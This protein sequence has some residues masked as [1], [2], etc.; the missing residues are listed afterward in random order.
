M[1]FQKRLEFIS[2]ILFLLSADERRQLW[3][4]AFAVF[5]MAALEVM[6]IASIT[7][8]IALVTN[9]SLVMSNAVLSSLFTALGFQSIDHFIVF[10]GVLALVVIVLSNS[11]SALMNW[12]LLNFTHQ[13]MHSISLRL[14]TIYLSQPYSFFLNRNSIELHRNVLG[15]VNRIVGNILIPLVFL[16]A[17]SVVAILIVLL[18]FAF[19]PVLA[20]SVFLL[21]GSAYTFIFW[22]VR[23]WLAKI[24]RASIENVA[25][26]YQNSNEALQ[27]IK[28]IKLLGVEGE[29]RDR[30]DHASYYA[31]RYEAMGQTISMLPRYAL[32]TIAFGSVIVIVLYLLSTGGDVNSALPLIVL[33]AFSGYRLLPAAQNIYASATQIRFNLSALDAIWADMS[34]KNDADVFKETETLPIK[35]EDE[36]TL[37][38]ISFK[39]S[40]RDES[41]LDGI[42]LTIRAR[43]TVGIVGGSGAGKTTFADVLLGLIEPSSG[44]ILVDGN[45]ITK[46][47]IA[48]WR[49]GLGYVPQSIYL[50]DSS[51]AA[52]I[53]FGVPEPSIDMNAVEKAARGA[54]LHDFIVGEL[55]QGYLTKVGD[56]GVRLSGGQRQRVAIAR[57]LY[58]EPEFLIL[59]EATSALDGITEDIVMEAING[60]AH[61]KTLLIIAHRIS[62]LKECDEIFILANGKFIAR[63]TYQELLRSNAEFRAMAKVS[64]D[65]A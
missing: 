17:R 16:L 48:S 6:G 22:K 33:Y 25:D 63:G 41:V 20:T 15:E 56:R 27:G 5:L 39:Y 35:V 31:A 23:R 9:R 40:G 21:V 55:T 38:N 54:N 2:K 58:R 30:F 14:L 61:R 37:S 64:E 36:V 19:D 11:F 18:L 57:A 13:R 44:K 7:P 50:S 12:V 43:T 4:M 3:Q 26:R 53:A 52:N 29:F 34:L 42:S 45:L 24:G 1:K 62:T 10:I 32:E 60:F 51:I 59:D 46:S 47:N 65:A 28:D 8:F 49:A